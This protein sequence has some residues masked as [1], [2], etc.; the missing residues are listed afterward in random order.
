M[1]RPSRTRNVTTRKLAA[2]GV[3]AAGA[4]VYGIAEGVRRVT[5]DAT[6]FAIG[7]VLLAAGALGR[8]ERYWPSGLVLVGWGTAVLLIHYHT[9]SPA[10]T[11][12]AYMLGIGVGLLA[13]RL[14]AP[15][16]ERGTWL[17]SAA[18]TSTTGPMAYFLAFDI[19][20]LGRWPIWTAALAIWAAGDGVAAVVANRGVTANA[21]RQQTE[22]G[23]RLTASA[24]TG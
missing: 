4:A 2:A 18:I 12:P 15:R 8:R 19:D 10:R 9:I 20:A 11:T 13:V 3:V 5:F 7:L 23:Q 1:I 22:A 6:P 14:V 16:N 21:G 24:P 17:A